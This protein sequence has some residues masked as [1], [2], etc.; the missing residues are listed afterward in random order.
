[1]I[2]LHGLTPRTGPND[3]ARDPLPE[4]AIAAAAKLARGRTVLSTFG[5]RSL[6]GR[7]L[8][9]AVVLFILSFAT[10]WPGVA[11]AEIEL[12]MSGKPPSDTISLGAPALSPDGRLVAMH[13]KSSDFPT[14]QLVV[15]DLEREQL[16]TFDQPAIESWVNPSFSPSGDRIVFIRACTTQC[17]GERRGFQVSL[18]DL[19]TGATTIETTG[20]R[21]YRR[22]PIFSPDERAIVFSIRRIKDVERVRSS[23]YHGVSTGGLRILHLH[24]GIEQ[25]ILLERFGIEWFLWVLP[26]GFLDGNTLILEGHWP[27]RPQNMANAPLIEKLKRLVGEKDAKHGDYAY[28]LVFD[29]PFSRTSS[30]RR[31]RELELIA[32]DR[33]GSLSSLTVSSDAGRMAFFGRSDRD[34]PGGYFGYD[35]YLGD[36]ETF[37]QATF[38]RTH[39]AGTA[40]SKSGNRV[41]FLADDT[42]Q[43][44]W[45][46]WILEV[47]SGRVWETSLKERLRAFHLLPTEQG[48]VHGRSQ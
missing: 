2:G 38:L 36:G 30:W 43:Q 24:T 7:R 14:H 21:V 10:Q 48:A 41:A 25:D 44:R 9:L 13:V 26:A 16:R 47:D 46:L 37:R 28:K 29:Q 8:L 45:S 35:V 34:P 15:F 19:K 5:H 12:A 33:T 40:I 11:R 3:A 17:T 27:S 18:L 1:M 4:A 20:T 39:M 32:P 23:R 31:T 42:R 22:A 6:S